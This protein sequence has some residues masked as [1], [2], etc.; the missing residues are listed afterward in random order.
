M[1]LIYIT[2][3]FQLFIPSKDGKKDTNFFAWEEDRM[4]SVDSN[5]NF[6]CGRPH[7]A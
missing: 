7:G 4:T 3:K 1:L 2:E 5:L 6:L